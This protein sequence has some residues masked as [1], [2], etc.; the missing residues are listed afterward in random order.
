VK[1]NRR[2]EGTYRLHLQGRILWQARNQAGTSCGLQ[3]VGLLSPDSTA[4][5]PSGKPF[6]VLHNTETVRSVYA[7]TSAPTNIRDS[8]VGIATGY[9]Q[10][11]DGVGVK[12]LG[13]VK[14]FHFPMS[15]RSAL[16]PTQPPP[17][18]WVPAAKQQGRE[19]DH[20]P[21]TSAEV[22]QTWVCPLP[23]TLS[24][25]SVWLVLHGDNL[26]KHLHQHNT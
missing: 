13:R 14:N 3:N 20:S 15:S 2:F 19:A 10:D 6:Q 9:G 18:Q 23:H 17:I 11:D 7:W 12:S 21:P 26:L 24:W 8:A 22:K 4:L 5:Y 25:R 1:V 16:E